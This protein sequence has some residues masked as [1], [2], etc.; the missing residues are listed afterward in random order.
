MH[1]VYIYNTSFVCVYVHRY[2]YS[3]ALAQ[4][5]AQHPPLLLALPLAACEQGLLSGVTFGDTNR[6]VPVEKLTSEL[7]PLFVIGVKVSFS[8]ATF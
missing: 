3:T 4:L 6:D 8:V 7:G 5:L 1:V 2:I